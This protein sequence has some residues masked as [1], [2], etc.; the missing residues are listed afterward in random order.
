MFTL[1]VFDI[2]SLARL[3]QGRFQ[4]NIHLVPCGQDDLLVL[5]LRS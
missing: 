4:I 1:R 2:E 3:S 5:L